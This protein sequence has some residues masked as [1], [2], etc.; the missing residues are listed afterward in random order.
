MSHDSPIKKAYFAWLKADS[1]EASVTPRTTTAK[2][3]ELSEATARAYEELSRLLA[4]RLA[5]TRSED[6][7]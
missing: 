3:L 7:E 6:S 5:E 1:L 2:K 4:D